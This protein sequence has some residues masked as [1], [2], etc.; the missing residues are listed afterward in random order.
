ML[1]STEEI[2]AKLD[3]IDLVQEYFPLKQAGVNFKANCPFHEEKTPSF[4]VNRERQFFHCFG[5]LKSGDVFT[6]IQEIENIEFPEALKI[7]ANKAGVRLPEYNP[8]RENLKTKMLKV[9]EEAVYFFAG[10]LF[11]SESGKKALSY[12]KEKRKLSE[13]TIKEWKLGYSLDGWDGLLTHLKKKEFSD[14]ELLK[15]GLVVAKDGGRGYYDRFRDRV[16][17]P[18]EDYH[19]NIVGFTGRAMKEDEMAKYVNTPQTQLYNKSEVIFGLY[20]AKEAIKKADKVVVVEGNMDVI[21]S[22]AVGVKNVV[23]VSGT[24]LTESQVR[25]LKRLTDNFCFCFDADEAGVRA[26]MRSIELVWHMEVSVQ[27][28]S[29]DKK[30]GKDPDDIIRT[31]VELWKKLIEEAK[32][33]MEYFFDMNFVDFKSDDIES[34]KTIAKNLLNLIIKLSSPIEQDYYIKKLAEKLS[35]REESLREAV[36]KAKRVTA[37]KN[38]YREEPKVEEKKESVSHRSDNRVIRGERLIAGLLLDLE[39]LE[40]VHD[41]LM[42]EYLDSEIQELYKMVVVYYTK[43][44]NQSTKFED[45]IAENRKDLGKQLNHILILKDELSEL[46]QAE[47]LSE[48]KLLVSELKRCYVRNKLAQVEGEIKKIEEKLRNS[49]SSEKEQ[50]TVEMN[51]LLE[52]FSQL[53]GQLKQN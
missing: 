33:A 22:H 7:L 31:D 10:Q 23:A 45:F 1:S 8:E 12:L 30:V 34:K 4:M 13:E 14:D 15:S 49:Y 38:S 6:F 29:I 35:T 46:S 53:S 17:F 24:A 50:I 41:N 36:E 3:I 48:I 11:N 21:A 28:I 2:K 5:C 39:Y 42:I 20:S 9:Q 27:V 52:E 32:P 43:Q 40:Y 37:N 47:L 18:I 19:G 44:Y 25:I 51:K 26:M 16:M